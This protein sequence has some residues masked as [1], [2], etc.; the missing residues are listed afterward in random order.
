MKDWNEKHRPKTFKDFI[1]NRD[2][3]TAI[4]GYI[5]SDS[6][7]HLLLHGHWGTGKTTLAEV[8]AIMLLGEDSPN[9]IELNASDDREE[10]DV[11]KL[12]KSLRNLPI[13]FS[14]FRVVLFD[15]ADGLK[16]TAQDLLKRPLEKVK[17]TVFVFTCNEKSKIIEPIQSRCHVFE[18][19]RLSDNDIIEGLKRIAVKE[20]LSL[21]ESAL[22]EIARICNGDMRT[23]I[24]ELQ[25][26]SALNN[27]N[28]EI[29]RIVQQYMK[30]P[31]GAIAV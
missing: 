29:D 13:G 27:R 2:T 16:P 12:L 4:E 24:N 19:K 8:I 11:K 3:L 10:K 15:E 20:K 17:N 6:I 26:A 21:D 28:V 1:G 5:L 31:A 30:Q 18:F 7:P 9:F 25:K 14:K 22:R 23:A